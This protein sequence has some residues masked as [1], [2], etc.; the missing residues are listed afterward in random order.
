MKLISTTALLLAAVLTFTGCDENTDDACVYGVQLDLDKGNY[1][2][3][4]TELDNNGSCN[5]A[6]SMTDS[7][8]NLAA[9]YNGKAGLTV[10]KLLGS[11]I[12]S[13]G[14]DPMLSFMTSFAASATPD[15]LLNLEKARTVYSYI[16]NSCDGN[17][18]GVQGEACLF[19][20]LTTLTQAVGSLTAII[21][22][23]TLAILSADSLV[24]G[25]ADDVD[26]STT[27]DQLEITACAI[28]D[29][30]TSLAGCGLSPS[31]ATY[32]ASG[33]LFLGEGDTTNYVVREYTVASADL[34]SFPDTVEYKLINTDTAP[35]TLV[36][37]NGLAN[38]NGEVCPAIAVDC[39]PKPVRS[40]DGNTTTVTSGLLVVL[41]EGGLDS[42]DALLPSADDGT[43]SNVTGDLQTTIYDACVAAGGTCTDDNQVDE[44]ELAAYL[45][46]L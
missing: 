4:V 10:S 34:A 11:V 16:D 1:D 3:V 38:A 30:S 42:M 5:G 37:T 8:L 6:M 32:V 25:G 17:E 12:G 22:A 9:A 41:N 26:G 39:F 13:D 7:W 33:T 44:E 40:E 24:T 45:E 19:D 36:T 27:A 43:D 21:G 15:G 28:T 29:A 2:S 31:V 18:T 35:D 20:G 46:N 14:A 23:D